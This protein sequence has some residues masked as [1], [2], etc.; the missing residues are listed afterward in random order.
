MSTL[1]MQAGRVDECWIEIERYSNNVQ[2]KKPRKK[3]D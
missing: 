3:T 2:E 1:D